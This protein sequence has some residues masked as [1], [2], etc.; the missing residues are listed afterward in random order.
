MELTEARLAH[1]AA[2]L[3]RRFP[4]LTVQEVLAIACEILGGL[5]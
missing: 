1:I 2:V 4:N 5:S 3:K